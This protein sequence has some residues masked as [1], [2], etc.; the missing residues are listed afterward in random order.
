MAMGRTQKILTTFLWALAVV[1][2]TGVVASG[3]WTRHQQ[4]PESTVML[5]PRSD[6]DQPPPQ[7]AL[8]VYFD[9]PDFALKNQDGALVTNADLRGHPYV[10]TFIFT[11]CAGTCPMMSAKMAR[12]QKSIPDTAV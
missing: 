10:A 8:P 6:D 12:L 3:L 7:G 9:A 4:H 1:G 2:M 11:H 5:E